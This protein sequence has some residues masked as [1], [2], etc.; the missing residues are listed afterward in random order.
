MAKL[1]GDESMTMSDYQQ[2]TDSGGHTLAN[3]PCSACGDLY[4]CHLPGKLRSD[5]LTFEQFW[6]CQAAWSRATLGSDAERGPEGPLKH[7]AKEAAEALANQ[8]D[9]MEYADCLFLV[10]D[11]CRRA[12]F[13]CEELRLAV[14][15]KLKINQSRTWGKA[16]ATEAVEHVREDGQ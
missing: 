13:S 10:F 7:L 2:Q 14:N 16:S 5:R 4:G 8:E 12:G 15:R 11:S 3:V 6:H 9:V 1:N